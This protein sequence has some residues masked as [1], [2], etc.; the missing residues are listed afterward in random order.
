MPE[1]LLMKDGKFEALTCNDAQQAHMLTFDTKLQWINL[2]VRM[3]FV[4]IVRERL[5]GN[6]SH[7]NIQRAIFDKEKKLLIKKQKTTGLPLIQT[8]PELP[9]AEAAPT[10]PHSIELKKNNP[11]VIVKYRAADDPDLAPELV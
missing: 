5:H 4:Q 9:S 7:N 2:K 11:A 6:Q 8:L 10:Q 3:R 1:T